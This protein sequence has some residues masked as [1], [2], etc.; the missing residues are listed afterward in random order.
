NVPL[1]SSVTAITLVRA[2]DAHAFSSKVHPNEQFQ[3]N[4]QPANASLKS[5]WDEFKSQSASG[6]SL[7]SVWAEPQFQSSVIQF[8]KKVLDE[9]LLNSATTNQSSNNAWDVSQCQSESHIFF[10]SVWNQHQFQTLGAPHIGKSVWGTDI[11]TSQSPLSNSFCL[12]EK[13]AINDVKKRRLMIGSCILAISLLIALIIG[14]S[15]GIL[16]NTST[17]TTTTCFTLLCKLYY[18][19]HAFMKQPQQSRLPQQPQLL[20]Q[21]RVPVQAQLAQLAQ[22]A[23]LL[24]LLQPVQPVQLVQLVQLAQLVQPVQPVQ[25]AQLVLQLQLLQQA[26]RVPLVQPAQPV[27][28]LQL[29]QQAQRAR[30]AP[31]RQQRRL[32]VTTTTMVPLNLLVDPGAESSGLAGWTQTGSSAVLQDT[33]GLEYSGY[34]PHTGSACFAGGFGSGGSPSSLL[35]NVNLLNG[36]QNFSTAQLDAGTLHAK[37]SF[38]YQTYYNWLYPYDDAEVIITF[39]SNTNAV[40]GTQDTGYQTCTSNN[41]GWCY[42]SNL[43]SLPVGTRSIDYKMIFTR[44]SGSKIGAYMDDNSL[45]L[46]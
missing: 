32:Q 39:L 15:L 33:G 9:T 40:L 34:N 37:I 35:Q 25:P 45:T 22:L 29:L 26:Q 16:L 42:Y 7:R 24:Q 2:Q 17:I 10:N 46:V 1:S 23:L 11:N 38:Y 30:Q 8:T 28:Q 36:I 31:Q 41:P 12:D 6:L 21:V 20:P 19:M 14:I 18:D 3:S 5:D 43:Y 13:S 27:L 4:L 44:N